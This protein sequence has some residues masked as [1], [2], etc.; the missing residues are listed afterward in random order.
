MDKR[1]NGRL[2]HLLGQRLSLQILVASSEIVPFTSLDSE[3]VP[4]RVQLTPPC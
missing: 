1:L 3:N 4:L 2:V